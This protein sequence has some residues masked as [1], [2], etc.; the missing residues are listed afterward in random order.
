[1][2]LEVALAVADLG[3]EPLVGAEVGPE[4]LALEE[5]IHFGRVVRPA[6]QQGMVGEGAPIPLGR[7]VGTVGGAAVAPQRLRGDGVARAGPPVDVGSEDRVVAAI[8]A[9][10]LWSDS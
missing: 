2:G 4:L 7:Q 9:Q 10:A 1:A 3:D 6:Q 8:A 5:P